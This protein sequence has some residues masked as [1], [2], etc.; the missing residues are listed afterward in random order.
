MTEAAIYFPYINVPEKAWFSRVLLYWDE[1]GSIVPYRYT[2]DLGHL[3]RYTAKL[4]EANLVKPIIPEQHTGELSRAMEPFLRY[5]DQDPDIE[6]RSRGGLGSRPASRGAESPGTI[7]QV[8]TGKFVGHLVADELIHRG[9]A[10]RTGNDWY[11]VESKTASAFM[12]HLAV[13][14]GDCAGRHMD[15]IT[16]Q[17]TNL[18]VLAS[19]EARTEGLRL[20]DDIRMSVL[21]AV[22][23]APSAAIE[24]DQLADFKQR[25]GDELRGFR[26]R[27]ERE[28]IDLASIAD[29]GLREARMRV[30][31]DELDAEARVIQAQ[32][33]VRGW[34]RI[35]FGSV[36]GVGATAL[37]AGAAAQGDP[38]TQAAAGGLLLLKALYEVRKQ[39]RS[40]QQYLRQPLA[41]AALAR[42]SLTVR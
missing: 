39:F 20:A 24:V 6:A 13:T 28:L 8:H 30:I 35:E 25:H 15:P 26:R 2:Q 27:V 23:P 21:E 16:D 34:R 5:L 42:E 32:M 14:L 22:L 36:C 19:T 4:M 40:D 37:A 33:R 10:R 17:T 9:L 29:G 18:A 41:Y 31:K 38:V 7:A 1:I 3:S 11:E 12:L